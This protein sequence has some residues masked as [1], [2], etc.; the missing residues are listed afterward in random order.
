MTSFATTIAVQNLWAN[1]NATGHNAGLHLTSGK[2]LVLSPFDS[3]FGL[4]AILTNF[5][6]QPCEPTIHHNGKY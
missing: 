1:D 2:R 5:Y 4:V 6:I 3:V